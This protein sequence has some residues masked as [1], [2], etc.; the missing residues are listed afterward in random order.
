MGYIKVRSR[1]QWHEHNTFGDWFCAMHLQQSLTT[2]LEFVESE[3]KKP[4][5]Q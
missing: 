3:T 2:P 4:N 5:R 1:F